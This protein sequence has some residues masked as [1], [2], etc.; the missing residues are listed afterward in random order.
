M[1]YPNPATA[2]AITAGHSD[3]RLATAASAVTI[4]LNT[5]RWQPPPTSEREH[6]P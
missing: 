3:T 5:N 1:P 2:P 4:A 6:A